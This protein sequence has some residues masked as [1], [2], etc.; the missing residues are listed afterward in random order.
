MF[1]L[2]TIDLETHLIEESLVPRI[3]SACYKYSYSPRAILEIRNAKNSFSIYEKIEKHLAGCPTKN[4]LVGQNVSFDLACLVHEKPEFLP[5]VFSAYESGQVHDTM[6]MGKLKGIRDGNLSVTRFSLK[7]LAKRELGLMME[8]KT[9]E[10]IWRLRYSELDCVPL[11]KWPKADSEYAL[12]DVLITEKVYNK[13]LEQ[14]IQAASDTTEMERQTAA[15]WVLHLIG[16]YGMKV[17]KPR[18]LE[19][20]KEV[21]EEVKVGIAVAEKLGILRGNGSKDTKKLKELVKVAYNGLPPLTDKDKVRINRD[22]LKQSGNPDLIA[23]AESASSDKLLNT[24]APILR[25]GEIIHPRYNVLVNTGRTSCSSPNMQNPPR[26]GGFRELFEARE[27]YVFALC[28]YDQIELLALAQVHLWLFEKSSIADAVNEGKDLHIE[29]AKRLNPS[30]PQKYRQFSKVANY[31]FPGGLSARVFSIYAKA[32]GLDISEE[33]AVQ[34]RKAWLDTWPE[35]ALY[36][37]W[38]SIETKW[39][40]TEVTQFKSGR[41]RGN[42]SFTQFCNTLFQGLVADGAKAALFEVS[43]ACYTDT[44]SP[45]WGSR[46]IAFLH[47][48]IIL[49]SPEESATEAAAELSRIMI[50]NMEIF[51]PDISVGAEPYLSRIWSKNAKRVEKKGKL[52][53]WE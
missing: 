18:A 20:I 43:K 33:E 29:V 5:T 12:N 26:G 10:D 23:Y 11:S 19:W 6:I 35:M 39:G 41:I 49:E 15:A 48:E 7:D 40:N 30:D 47:D 53:P 44:Q 52:I 25:K 27:G 3:V 8:G 50:H 32:F 45:L 34:V 37:D 16:I 42:C 22:T 21:E 14:E 46:P 13:L 31:G 28:D 9:G 1:D 24:Y 36:F 17:N 51:I 4:K 38:I 2:L